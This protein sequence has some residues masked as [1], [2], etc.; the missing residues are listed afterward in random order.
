MN[1]Q[2]EPLQ[3]GDRV[4]I[5]GDYREFL[6]GRQGKIFEIQGDIAHIEFDNVAP[7]DRYAVVRLTRLRE[8]KES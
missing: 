3:V 2:Q 4:E 6:N 5:Q 8:V 1:E 7:V